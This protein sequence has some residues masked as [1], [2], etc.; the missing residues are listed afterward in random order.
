M[1]DEEQKALIQIVQAQLAEQR[2]RRR[3]RLFF[4][5]AF[6]GLFAVL[7]FALVLGPG[8]GIAPT[9]VG[10]H[11]A[12]IR[13]EGAIFADAGVPVG[14]DARDIRK[15]LREAFET[16]YARV[17]ILEINTPGGSPVQSAYIADEILRLR[18]EYP[19]KPLYAVIADLCMS[20]GMYAAAAA[21]QV[22]ADPA[23]LIGSI[24]VVFGGFG[25]VETMEKLGV[26]RRLMTAGRNKAMLDP[27]LP[28]DPGQVAHAQKLLDQV[29]AQFIERVKEGRKGKP[30]RGLG[31]VRRSVLDRRTGAGT[32]VDRRFRGRALCR[33]GDQRSRRDR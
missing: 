23:S 26:E 33:R 3:W 32:R 18:E 14:G 1:A 11:A 30:R 9:A 17:V 13:L 16:E 22:Y 31:V 15:S 29:H 12:L 20:G 10:E 24:G 8:V 27:F 7:V 2:L 25:F 21:D 4:R 6:L 5:F 28:E 19:D